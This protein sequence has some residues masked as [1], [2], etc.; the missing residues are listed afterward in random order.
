NGFMHPSPNSLI[1]MRDVFQAIEGHLLSDSE[2]AKRKILEALGFVMPDGQ[3]PRQYSLPARNG[4]CKADLRE[5]IDQGAWVISTV[6]TYLATTGD[7]PILDEIVGY[8]RI[9]GQ[10]GD[11]LEPTRERDSVADHLVRIMDYLL[12]HRDSATGLVLALYGDWNDA[13][14]GL[15]V[16]SR[17]CTRFGNGVS[18]MASLQVYRNCREMIEVLSRYGPDEYASLIEQYRLARE[19][20]R[21]GLQEHAVVERD[22][23]R[24]IV[25]GWGDN[26]EYLICSFED[27]DG[28]ARDGLTSNAFW[29]LSG[30]LQD[31]QD[32]L[33]PEILKAMRRLDSS[34]GFRTFAPG[35]SPDAPGV[36]RIAKLPIGTAENGAT[37]VHATTF[38][39]M[40]LFMMDE[41]EFAWEQVLKIL[42]FAPH[43]QG[44]SHSP[45]VMPNAYAFNPEL[46]LGGQNMNDWQTGSSNVLLKTLVR[47]AFGFRPG[48]D[49]LRIVPAAWSP[50]QRMELSAWAHRRPIRIVRTQGEAKERRFAVNG[51]PAEKQ[52]L[53]GF[54]TSM[55]LEIRYTELSKEC[56]NLIEI[57]DPDSSPLTCKTN[58]D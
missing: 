6:Y 52:Y 14:D 26:R 32:D 12:K 24:R 1:G 42:P 18:V 16:P 49:A 5:F 33:K 40:A 2:A 29:V 37:Y 53:V 7:W 38:G 25:H 15:G 22:G 31:T 57:R 20:L 28:K 17:S 50:F 46:N 43:Q 30:L 48:F 11:A 21:R 23:S 27:S 19:G 3:C 34:F 56:E 36:G 47:H 4:P 58:H 39:I 54:G 35:F 41:P 44:I 8:H 10:N 13:L 51:R 9:D 45:F 55:S